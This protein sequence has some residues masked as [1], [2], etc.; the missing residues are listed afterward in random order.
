MEEIRTGEFQAPPPYTKIKTRGIA[1]EAES[2][3][4]ESTQITPR[5]VPVIP[6]TLNKPGIVAMTE[7]L[8]EG[9]TGRVSAEDLFAR[10][11]DVEV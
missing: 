1:R 5:G 4:L 8:S 6:D 10:K 2:Q 7:A 3:G 11:L 9:G